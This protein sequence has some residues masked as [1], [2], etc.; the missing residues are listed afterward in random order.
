MET[1]Q[2]FVSQEE[3][4]D[5]LVENGVDRAKAEQ[6][7]KAL[8]AAWHNEVGPIKAAVEGVMD[9]NGDFTGLDFT[10]DKVKEVFRALGNSTLL[11][12]ALAEAGVLFIPGTMKILDP[13]P[14]KQGVNLVD[15]V[16]NS[17]AEEP[18]TIIPIHV[19]EIDPL[20]ERLQELKAD[21]VE[22]DPEEIHEET[23]GFFRDLGI[24]L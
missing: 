1:E 20:I 15:I 6:Q 18:V 23:R 13:T 19:S 9:E 10:D 24:E 16:S 5:A 8:T 12:S 22:P 11:L 4:I 7:V 21:L 17:H 2:Q 3:A 14:D